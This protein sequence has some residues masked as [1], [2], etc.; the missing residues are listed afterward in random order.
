MV[1]APSSKGWRMTSKTF[2]LNSGNSSKNKTPLWD[3]LTSPGRGMAPPPIS[4]AS[5]MVWCGDRNGRV[6]IMP[7]PCGMSPATE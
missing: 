3:R 1:T 5:E 4:P 2:F 6:A 7:S